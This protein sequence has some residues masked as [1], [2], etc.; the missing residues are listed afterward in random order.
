MKRAQSELLNIKLIFFVTY[1]NTEMWF[2]NQKKF[3][4]WCAESNS[5][6]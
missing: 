2:T 3:Q 5:Q 1:I 4:Y 6:I